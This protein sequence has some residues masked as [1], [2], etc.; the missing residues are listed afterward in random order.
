MVERMRRWSRKKRALFLIALAVLSGILRRGAAA[1]TDEVAIR[2]I[3]DL[4]LIVILMWMTITFFRVLLREHEDYVKK[5]PKP[6]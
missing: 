5:N 4:A 2:L 6:W 3:V 1:L